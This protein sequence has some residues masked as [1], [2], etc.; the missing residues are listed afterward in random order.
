VE[1]LVNIPPTVLVWLTPVVLIFLIIIM[2]QRNTMLKQSIDSLQQSIDKLSVVLDKQETILGTL[3]IKLATL[4][5]ELD[6]L[7]TWIK[8]HDDIINKMRGDN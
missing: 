6:I 7:K 4:E 3:S 8:K 1:N 5:A 2:E